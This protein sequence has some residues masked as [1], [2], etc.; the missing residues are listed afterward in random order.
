MGSFNASRL[1]VNDDLIVFGKPEIVKK[2]Q[3]VSDWLLKGIIQSAARQTQIIYLVLWVLKSK[4]ETC[5]I[6]INVWNVYQFYSVWCL[7]LTNNA[8]QNMSADILKWTC[9]SD[10]SLLPLSTRKHITKRFNF[11]SI[12]NETPPVSDVTQINKLKCFLWPK[13][14][15]GNLFFSSVVKKCGKIE[16]L[17]Q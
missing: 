12:N 10:G 16:V 2:N 13:D 11:Q 9:V 6:Q 1:S 14:F 8:P 7:F 17:L 3:S 4:I 15:K 5:D